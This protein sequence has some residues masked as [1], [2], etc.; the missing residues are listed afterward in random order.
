MRR[1]IDGIERCNGVTYKGNRIS[2]DKVYKKY[3]RKGLTGDKKRGNFI[4][5]VRLSSRVFKGEKNISDIEKNHMRKIAS[6]IKQKHIKYNK[7]KI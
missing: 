6:V 1:K 2:Y 7:E 5:Y 4:S 3:S